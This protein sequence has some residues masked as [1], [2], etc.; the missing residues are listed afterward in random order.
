VNALGNHL[1]AIVGL[2]LQGDGRAININH[3][4]AAL[5]GDSFWNGREVFDFDFTENLDPAP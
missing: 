5:D 3:L 1:N 4:G 2:K